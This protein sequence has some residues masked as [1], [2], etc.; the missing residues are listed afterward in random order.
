MYVPVALPGPRKTVRVKLDKRAYDII[1]QRGCLT[2]LGREMAQAI[3]GSDEADGRIVAVLLNP[4]VDYYLGKAIYESLEH[5]RFNVLP[6]SLVAG[7][8]Y[9]TLNTVRRVY[10]KLYA[11]K[12]DRQTIILAAGGGVIGDVAGYVASTYQRGIDY[13]QL[14]TTLL[15]QVDS[16]V[17]GKV[18]VN[19]RDA[20]NAIG[21]FYQ[22]K[23]VVI[24][25][26]TL[27]TLPFRERRS[28]LAEI[29]KYGAIA[30][31]GFFEN[32]SAE[33]GPL[34]RLTSSYLETAIAH[35][36]KIKARVVEQDE[37]DTGLR[38]ILNFG[39]TVGHALEALTRYRIYRHG[40]AIAIGMVSACLI[41]EEMGVTSPDVTAALI[42]ILKRADFPVRLDER[43]YI[44][45]IIQ[46]TQH[47]KKSVAGSARFVLLES[48]GIATSGHYVPDD[49]VRAAL[50]RQRE[51]GE[52]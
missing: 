21:A 4:K 43:L 9:K 17:G 35:S 29:I 18:G 34:L 30:D 16:S 51:L 23:L 52:G 3:L 37:R 27:K 24:D 5:A 8:T 25:P 49:V 48:L 15:A 42:G 22:P 12:A 6:V 20:K 1:V 50:H 11:S 26:E 32:V 44:N 28:G 47:D 33:I 31:V 45:D 36:C 46:L 38:A 13:V 2:S 10:D 19:Y 39:H 40:E 7:E 41:G 14:P